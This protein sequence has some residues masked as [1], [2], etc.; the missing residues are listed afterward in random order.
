[1]KKNLFYVSVLSA[2]ILPVLSYAQFQGIGG[3]LTATSS[4]LRQVIVIIFGL[5]MIYFFWGTSQFILNSGDAKKREEGKQ[6]ML[7]GII[8]LFVMFSIFGILR[9]I[10]VTTGISIGEGTG[11]VNQYET[12]VP[13]ANVPNSCW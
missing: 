3:L 10:S 7:W 4:L 11:G 1:M 13:E 2:V 12:C 6:K 5:A 8:A 9:F